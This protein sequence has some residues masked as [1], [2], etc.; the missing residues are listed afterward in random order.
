[1]PVLKNFLGN[2]KQKNKLVRWLNNF[3]RDLD[4]T[5]FFT[6]VAD[7]GNGKTYIAE[8]LAGSFKV[9]LYTISP[10]DIT[11][12]NDIIQIKKDL[13]TLTSTGKKHRLVLID[14]IDFYS[15][16]YKRQLL[17]LIDFSQHP[18]I[19]TASDYQ[20][21]PTRLKDRNFVAFIYKPFPSVLE[22]HLERLANAFNLK[23]SKDKL[24][25]IADKSRSVRSAKLSL[26]SLTPTEEKEKSMFDVVTEFYDG[27]PVSLDRQ[28][29]LWIAGNLPY[30]LNIKNF[31]I[32]KNLADFDTRL[33]TE[34]KIKKEETTLF[35]HKLNIVKVH[36][37]SSFKY[38]T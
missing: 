32:L 36:F 3:Y 23:I 28:R 4:I 18:I 34:K 8:C 22:E 17:S 20:K 15:T 5:N 35:D 6:I 37:P 24:H 11:S 16:P 12:K 29:I 21:V 38:R 33:N 30:D 10:Y 27:K 31:T 9:P 13:I 2:Q 25:E 19:F 26:L 1:M 14:D 7:P